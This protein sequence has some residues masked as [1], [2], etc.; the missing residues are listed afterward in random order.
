[1]IDKGMFPDGQ[2]Y[3]V[4]RLTETD[5]PTVLRLQNKVVQDLDD[6][7]SLQ[8]LS[9]EEFRYITS[10]NGLLIGVFVKEELIS[11]RALVVPDTM[12]DHLGI[13]AGLPESELDFVIYQDIS[14]VDPDWRGLSLQR[15]MA[16]WIMDELARSKHPYKYVC[17]TVAP[18]N[19]PSLKDKFAQGMEIVALK[20]KYGGNLRY[21]F[22]KELESSNNR[23][24]EPVL[25]QMADTKGQQ[26]LL[27]QGYRGQKLVV[28]DQ[29][30]YVEFRK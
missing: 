5:I 8:P 28:I 27:A 3:V 6:K 26:K 21:I 15:R 22:F 29:V 12:E 24:G 20:P 17:S 4:R 23:E 7:T 9:E 14:N 25:C 16:K 19:I 1:M 11:F 10:G 18:F 30:Y 13:D 2:A